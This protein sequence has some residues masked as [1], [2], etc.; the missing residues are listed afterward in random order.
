MIEIYYSGAIEAGGVQ[1][2]PENS[3][4]GFISK[5]RLPNN[6]FGNLFSIASKKTFSLRQNS[7][8]RLLFLKNVSNESLKS[9][10]FSFNND[11][12]HFQYKFGFILP[13]S[14]DFVEKIEKE[15]QFP[16]YCNWIDDLPV[17]EEIEV[18]E[19]LSSKK[20][21]AMWVNRTTNPNFKYI[22]A[23]DLYNDFLSKNENAEQLFVPNS[24]LID[25]LLLKFRWF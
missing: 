11:S 1:P 15:T 5:N 4:G 20:L 23:E 22:S 3:L 9:L 8:N 17:D 12:K 2:L 24:Q 10:K 14:D 16:Y 18:S 21:I 19:E 7:I 13:N 6:D 25:D